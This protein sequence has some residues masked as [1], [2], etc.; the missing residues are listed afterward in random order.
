[1]LEKYGP[2]FF[3]TNVENIMIDFLAK[4]ISTTQL[5]K[6]LVSSKALLLQLHL[7]G[8]FSGNKDTVEKEIKYI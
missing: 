7:T 2:E 5:N 4:H 1:M 3:E 8:N 6:L